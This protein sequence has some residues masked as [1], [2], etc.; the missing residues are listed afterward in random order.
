[1]SS[2]LYLVKSVRALPAL[3]DE[4]V[5]F[6]VDGWVVNFKIK[7]KE[8]G[9]TTVRVLRSHAKEFGQRLVAAIA[10]YEA[11]AA[12]KYQRAKERKQ[13]RKDKEK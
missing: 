3:P 11:K 5:S 9:S 2:K 10:E 1:M 13:L 12:A 6:R 8:E 4:Y 7:S